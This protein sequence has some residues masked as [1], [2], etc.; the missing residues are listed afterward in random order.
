MQYTIIVVS[1]Y[2]NLVVCVYMSDRQIS[3]LVSM[4]T[5]YFYGC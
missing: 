4:C 1:G 2:A 5:V 3:V